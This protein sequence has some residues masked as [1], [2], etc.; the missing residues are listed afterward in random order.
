MTSTFVEISP[1][2]YQITVHVVDQALNG[3]VWDME[4]FFADQQPPWSDGQAGPGPNGWMPMTVTG[5]I[6][7]V[8]Q[9][10]PLLTCQPVTFTFQA[11]AS[12][13]G[14]VIWLHLTDREH[15]NMGNITS[16]RVPK[17]GLTAAADQQCQTSAPHTAWTTWLR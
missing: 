16:T 7:W 15:H 8:T 14:D 11:P 12:Q 9:D 4:I 6:G 1:G 10:A 17:P 5:G 3:L 2:V 13:V